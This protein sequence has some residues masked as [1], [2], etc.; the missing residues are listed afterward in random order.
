MKMHV[1]AC[2]A[3]SLAISAQAGERHPSRKP[4]AQCQ[5]ETLADAQV[6]LEAFVQRCHYDSRTTDFVFRNGSLAIRYS[7]A[8]A[9]PEPVVDVLDLGPNETAEA[10]ITRFFAAH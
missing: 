3:V 10:G 4:A 8:P 2:C 6:G 7:D 1:W 9:A 5:W